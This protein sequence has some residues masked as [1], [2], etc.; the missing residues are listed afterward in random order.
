[1]LPLDVEIMSGFIESEDKISLKRSKEESK[2]V[3]ED[4]LGKLV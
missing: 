1:V 4:V 3:M 2:S